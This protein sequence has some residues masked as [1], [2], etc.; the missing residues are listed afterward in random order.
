[1]SLPKEEYTNWLSSANQS[2]LKTQLQVALYRF[3]RFYI[4]IYGVSGNIKEYTNSYIHTVTID[5]KRLNFK[6]GVVYE[7]VGGRK[8]E[9]K[10]L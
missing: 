8:G 10:I 7:S 4:Y 2:A 1:M 3:N 6:E 5:K 9:E